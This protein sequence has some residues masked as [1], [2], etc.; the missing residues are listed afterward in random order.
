[1]L[2]LDGYS[3]EC[4]HTGRDAVETCR[5]NSPDVLLLD[6]GLP[7][8]S[9]L[10][11]IA[12][13][14][15]AAPATDILIISGYS[16]FDNAVQAV[17]RSTIGY[18]VK[19]LDHDRLFAILERTAER[20]R[21]AI[22]NQQ[23]WER[24]RQ[25]KRRW[26]STFDAISD[27]IVIV[28]AGGIV[29]HCNR[30]FCRRFKISCE[31]AE[32]TTAA[33]LMVGPSSGVGRLATPLS[34]RQ[35]EEWDD[36]VV[37]G[38]FQVS[39][40]PLKLGEERCMIYVLR[41]VTENKRAAVEREELIG[42]LEAKNKELERYA[43]TVSHD[44]RSPLVTIS[45]F[46]GRLEADALEGD[47]EGVR[48]DVGHI[49]AAAQRMAELLDGLLDLSRIGY[50]VK[51][52]EDVSLADVAHQTLDLVMFTIS[53]RKVEVSIAS[54]LPTVRGDRLGLLQV[55]QNLVDN[56]IKFMGEQQRPRMTIGARTNGDEVVCY[57]RDNGIGI[58]PRYHENIF[59]LFDQLDRGVD[60]AGLGLAVVERI[61][62]AHGGRVWIESEGLGKG[63]TFYFS[64]PAN[65]A[66]A[67][68]PANDRSVS[69]NRLPSRRRDHGRRRSG[70]RLSR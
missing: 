44:L 45:G 66:S 37:P 9:G 25:S 40:D 22:E 7:D 61:I 29:L 47:V 56:A 70:E 33:E 35:V 11:L 53:E 3:V 36:L 8:S 50:V 63:T 60:G 5:R 69:A 31:S 16:A 10:D 67:P 2:E 65:K 30:A 27:P 39:C 20:N 19:P 64:L 54:D 23:L 18:L 28:D 68:S 13:V 48:R 52:C 6:I 38:V 59:G 49:Q 4:V 41:D 58:D 46:A 21:V 15:Q 42:Q 1:M 17:S 24:V 32:G 26:E 14:E 55:F 51:P 12:Q 34:E 57:V 43:Y 62:Q